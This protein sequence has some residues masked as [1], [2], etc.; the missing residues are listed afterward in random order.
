MNCFGN[1]SDYHTYKYCKKPYFAI[2]V[3]PSREGGEEDGNRNIT[4]IRENSR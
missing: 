3:S 2:L 1:P 4:S